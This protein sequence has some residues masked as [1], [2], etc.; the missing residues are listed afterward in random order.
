MTANSM[1]QY[2]IKTYERPFPWHI[3]ANGLSTRVASTPPVTSTATR[4]PK[5]LV[6]NLKKRVRTNI[7]YHRWM[8]PHG[9]FCRRSVYEIWR[10]PTNRSYVFLSDENPTE[11]S[12]ARYATCHRTE[13]R[14]IWP[15][16]DEV[17]WLW[18]G[19]PSSVGVDSCSFKWILN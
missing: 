18:S 2:I 12:S 13:R 8:M 19:Q 15:Q 14:L 3:C 10:W 6:T 9:H 5:K 1:I 17:S 11:Y 16:F 7:T 4:A